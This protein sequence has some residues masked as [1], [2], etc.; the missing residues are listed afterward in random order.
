MNA[1]LTE[2]EFEEVRDVKETHDETWRE[3]LLNAARERKR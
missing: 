1:T 2:A 3:F